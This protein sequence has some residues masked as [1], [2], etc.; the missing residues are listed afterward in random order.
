MIQLELQASF[1]LEARTNAFATQ[2]LGKQDLDGNA[3]FEM[4]MVPAVHV[5]HASFAHQCINLK[6]TNNF[7]S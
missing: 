7:A 4:E 2:K 3:F 5:G 1:A 6:L